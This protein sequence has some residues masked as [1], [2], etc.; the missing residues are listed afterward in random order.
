VATYVVGGNNQSTTFSGVIWDNYGTVA[1]TKTGS[2]T[3]TLSGTNTYTGGTTIIAGELQL[4]GTIDSTV[5]GGGDLTPGIDGVGIGYTGNL[6]LTSDSYYNVSLNDLEI[7]GEVVSGVNGISVTGTVTIDDEAVLNVVSTRT[8]EEYGGLWVLIQ[9][10]GT[11]A[12]D[13]TFTDLP[14]GEEFVVDDATY[15]ITYTYNAEERTFG[16]GNDVALVSSLFDVSSASISPLLYDETHDVNHDLDATQYAKETYISRYQLSTSLSQHDLDWYNGD[17]QFTFVSEDT[18]I[19]TVSSMGVVTFL[20]PGT[21]RILV[22]AS[23]EGGSEQTFEV[24]LIGS[25]SGGELQYLPDAFDASQ[26]L[27]V[28]YNAQSQ[29][30]CSIKDYYLTHRPGVSD[31]NYLGLTAGDYQTQGTIAHI[32]YAKTSSIITQLPNGRTANQSLCESIAQYVINW[33][34]EAKTR[35]VDPLPIRYVLGLYGLPFSDG[36]RGNRNPS[37]PAMIHALVTENSFI[38]ES[39]CTPNDTRFSIAEYNGPLLAWLDCG[40]YNATIAFIDKEEVVADAG[41]LL[42]DGVTICGAAAGVN[43]SKWIMDDTSNM[44]Y[45]SFFDDDGVSTSYIPSLLAEGVS[46]GNI[47]YQPNASGPVISTAEDPIAYGSWGQHAPMRSGGTDAWP[48]PKGTEPSVVTFTGNASW[49]IGMSIESF[50]GIY[51]DYMGDPTEF[52]AA[53]AFGGTNYSSTPVCFAVHTSEPTYG[54]CTQAEYFEGWARGWSSLEAAWAGRATGCFLVVTDVCLQNGAPQVF[55]TGNANVDED[56][57]YTL[58][59]SEVANLGQ[60]PGQGSAQLYRIAWDD[61]EIEWYTA[62]QIEDLD[63]ELTHTYADPGTVTIIVDLVYANS[64]FSCV[65]RKD[66]TVNDLQPLMAANELLTPTPGVVS[67]T[68]SDLQPIINEAIARWA[69]VGLDALTV[70]R[71]VQVQFVISDLSGSYLG[72]AGSNQI[73]IDGNAAGYGWFVDST[74]MANEEFTSVH[75]EQERAIDSRA[76]DKIDLLTVV[77]HELGHIAGFGDLD[78]LAENLMSDVLGRGI[79]PLVP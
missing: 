40:S 33:V 31:A 30:S 53:N 49:W 2:G 75:G 54:G 8:R 78:A 79:R 41:G 24:T 61:G 28:I 67:L 52:F 58:T 23:E 18:E 10:D 17:P 35:D 3:L 12:A 14:E 47:V 7:D 36:S 22:T 70:E 55:L 77:E 65:A 44:G 57:P 1:L 46:A 19:A 45:G 15:W 73:Y 72:K 63:R 74:P 71:L 68:Q 21:C 42:I 76:V 50:N 48:V 66:V 27:L 37:V 25:L 20:E 5:V 39:Y 69:S 34:Q 29:D 38:P 62:A 51:G 16:N 11:D 13:G 60:D 26:H 32:Y 56:S 43:G 4:G 9:N 59:L 6:S 64:S